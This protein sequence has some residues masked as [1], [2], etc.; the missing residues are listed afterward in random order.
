M[1]L[2]RGCT[3]AILLGLLWLAGTARAET[4][5]ITLVTPPLVAEGVNQLQCHLVNVS[6]EGRSAVIEVLAQDGT[7]L[8]TDGG[9]LDPGEAAVVTVPASA[10][11]RYCKFI[12][13][14]LRV[15]F[16]GSIAVRV[17]DLGSLSALPAH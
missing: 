12:V 4:F 15:D 11:S 13:E 3:F 7:V 17:P 9:T 6:G 10:S 16:R 5:S 2:K 14:G 8:E 1:I